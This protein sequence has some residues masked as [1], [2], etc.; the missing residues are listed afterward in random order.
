MDSFNLFLHHSDF[1]Y[2]QCQC[3]DIPERSHLK[4]KSYALI[5]SSNHIYVGMYPH[6]KQKEAHLLLF[7]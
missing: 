2:S 3:V 7:I 5:K 1:C 4:Q 6:H